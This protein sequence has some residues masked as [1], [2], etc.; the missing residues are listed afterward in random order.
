MDES[1]AISY[2]S[3]EA[4]GELFAA[5][6]K[7]QGEIK[8]AAKDATNPH[9]NKKYAGLASIADAC[10][11]ALS[12]NGIS[13]IQVPFNAGRDV[14]LTTMLGH[15]SGQ[16]LS[17][18]LCVAPAKW[19]AQGVGSVLTYLRR[20]CLAAM[21]GVAQAED[22]DDGEA[23]VDRSV[24]FSQPAKAPATRG[25]TRTADAQKPAQGSN[26]KEESAAKVSEWVAR[27]LK[28]ESYELV[29]KNPGGWPAWEKTYL[30]VC[31]YATHFDQIQKLAADNGAH[32]S[33]HREAVGQEADDL[34][35][36]QV[37][38][39]EKR[40]WPASNI[41]FVNEMSATA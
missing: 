17:G 4:L 21:S 8:N 29:P 18:T 20:Y 2:Q 16:W 15:S 19:D 24:S 3:S 36:A 38:A 40:L 34:F 13:V 1:P 32:F 23:A 37:A 5:L 11:S 26:A 27:F 41:D 6:A 39:E 14:G 10:R 33:G 12:K 9:F 31:R 35:R 30:A 28:R 22:D 25:T 7:A